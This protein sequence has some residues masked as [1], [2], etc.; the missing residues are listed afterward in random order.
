MINKLIDC[1]KWWFSY[2]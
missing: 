2:I 1:D